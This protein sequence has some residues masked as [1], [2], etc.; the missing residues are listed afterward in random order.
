MFHQVGTLNSYL[1]HEKWKKLLKNKL[2][3]NT[4][5]LYY[6][7]EEITHFAVARGH[8]RKCVMLCYRRSDVFVLLASDTY[9]C[10][11]MYW[12]IH[13]FTVLLFI[14]NIC[15]WKRHHSQYRLTQRQQHESLFSFINFY[16]PPLSGMKYIT[17][18]FHHELKWYSSHETGYFC[19][20]MRKHG[21][22]CKQR[23]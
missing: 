13:L 9:W 19:E 5:E 4:K 2:M 1:F 12:C 20:Y 17:V 8:R 3:L 16:F 21:V 11:L 22:W 7:H 23:L 14:S 10:D 18:Y 6:H 15:W